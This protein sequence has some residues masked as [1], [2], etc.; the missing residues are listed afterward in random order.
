MHQIALVVFWTCT[1]LFV[2]AC[3]AA[4]FNWLI[5]V[6]ERASSK[7]DIPETLRTSMRMPVSSRG[8]AASRRFMRIVI[9]AAIIWCVGLFVGLSA[10]IIH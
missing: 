3:I 5:M 4:L 1:S 10:D 8:T 2:A 6:A 7:R 9:A